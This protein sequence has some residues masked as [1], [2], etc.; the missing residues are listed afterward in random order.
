L[1][2]TINV[3]QN[4]QANARP[5]VTAP[6]PEQTIRQLAEAFNQPREMRRAL[7]AKS[8]EP[9]PIEDSNREGDDGA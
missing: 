3:A 9:V 6:S 5:V 4:A 8:S 2:T 1:Q 7:V